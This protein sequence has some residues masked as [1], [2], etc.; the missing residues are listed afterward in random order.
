MR[1]ASISSVALGTLNIRESDMRAAAPVVYSPA[2]SVFP[3]EMVAAN[4]ATK[5]GHDILCSGA[6]VNRPYLGYLSAVSNHAP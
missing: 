4:M 3:I 5:H 6:E 1:L 2:H